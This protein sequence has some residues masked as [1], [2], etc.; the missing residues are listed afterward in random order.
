MSDVTCK[1]DIIDQVKYRKHSSKH[2]LTEHEYHVQ[3]RDDVNHAGLK[4]SC[5][6]TQ[7]HALKFCGPHAKSHGMRVLSKHYHI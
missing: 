2:R 3:K 5:E 4:I 6:P 7:L 1:N